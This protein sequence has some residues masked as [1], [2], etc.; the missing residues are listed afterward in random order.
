M[1]EEEITLVLRDDFYRDSFGKVLLIIMGIFIAIILFV[2]TSIYLYM[3][4]PVPITFHVEDEFRILK[5]VALDQP[6][7]LS[8]DLLQWVGNALANS[9]V[10]DFDHYNDQLKLASQYF[11]PDGWKIFL[12]QLNIYANYNTVQKNKMFITNK[13]TGAPFILRQ[14]LLPGRRY[15]WWIQMPITISYAGY[16]ISS[17]DSLTLQILV[18]RVS[19]L[20]NLMGVGIDNV[21]VAK[22]TRNQETNT[23]GS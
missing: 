3:N 4:K 1:T 7:L 14:G 15:A 10:Y 20:N 23:I 21:I 17:T 8:P 11:T 16:N 5:P 18:V 12:N 2:A 6:Y 19:T 9:F 13:P 22:T